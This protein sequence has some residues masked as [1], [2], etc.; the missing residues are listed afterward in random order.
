MQPTGDMQPA[1]IIE[2][3]GENGERLTGPN[4]EDF[5]GRKTI[6]VFAEAEIS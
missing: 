2:A 6:A 3:Y 1:V 4:V 5:G